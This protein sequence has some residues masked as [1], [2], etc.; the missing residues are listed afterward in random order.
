VFDF[1]RLLDHSLSPGEVVRLFQDVDNGVVLHIDHLPDLA[2]LTGD[3]SCDGLWQFVGHCNRCEVD[4]A[5]QQL[6]YV[7]Q[8]DDGPGDQLVVGKTLS[9]STSKV[10]K[11]LLLSVVPHLL[12]QKIFDV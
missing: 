1:L 4:I 6:G 8:L 3:Q 12:H 2:R 11:F 7:V 5:E 10:F 9:H